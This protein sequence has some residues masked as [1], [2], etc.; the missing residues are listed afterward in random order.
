[1]VVLKES[2]RFYAISYSLR[3]QTIK[4]K[5][6]QLILPNS[7]YYQDPVPN[8]ETVDALQIIPDAVDTLQ[9]R[10]HSTQPTK[11]KGSGIFATGAKVSLVLIKLKSSTIFAMVVK[12][13]SLKE[14]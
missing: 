6:G 3:E 9:L 7:E 10:T 4:V 2:K 5:R 13:L 8:I 12:V 14:V 1:M 11:L